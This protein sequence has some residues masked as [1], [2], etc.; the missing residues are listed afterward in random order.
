MEDY[1]FCY[2]IEKYMIGVYEDRYDEIV[3]KLNIEVI[4]ECENRV[5][6]IETKT[7]GDFK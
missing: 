5:K 6:E 2:E 4:K 7:T 1:D 3:N